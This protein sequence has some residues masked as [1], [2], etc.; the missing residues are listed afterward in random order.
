M[1]A[2]GSVK[3]WYTFVSGLNTEGGYFVTPDGTWK[4]GR[5]I[6]PQTDGSIERRN[7]LDFETGY[8]NTI[9]YF[10]TDTNTNLAITVGKWS[11][12]NS[13]DLLVVQVGTKLHFYYDTSSSISSTQLLKEINLSDYVV[14]DN[15]AYAV[16]ADY[17]C[18][19][20]QAYG[21][22]VVTHRAIN[23][24]LLT[25][26]AVGG[27]INAEEIKIKVR[28]FEGFNTF[29]TEPTDEFTEAE[30]ISYY[31]SLPGS[32]SGGEDRAIYN[33]KNQGWN[34]AQITAY[35]TA[36]ANKLPANTKI[37]FYGKDSSDNFSASLLNKQ[38][39]GTGLAPKGR[40]IL[41]A[42]N[43]TRTEDGLTVTNNSFFR[44]SV[45]GFFAGRIWYAGCPDPDFSSKV[46][47]SQVL[48][49]IEKVG[50]C[51]QRNDPTS[52]I[53]SDLLDSDGGNIEVPEAGQ[54]VKL[55]A[56][57]RGLLIF[58]ENG[59]FSVSGLD[60]IFSAANYQVEKIS[61]VGT[62][63]PET[64]VIVNNGIMFWS[65]DGVY[66][67]IP[68]AG[69]LS[70]NVD[71]VSNTA[72]RTFYN[73]ITFQAK[74]KACGAYNSTTNEIAWLYDSSTDDTLNINSKKTTMLVYN[75]SIDSWYVHD[76][77]NDS[78]T[79]PAFIFV[80]KPNSTVIEETTVVN[81]SGDIVSAD[82]LYSPARDI[83]VES[84][85][86]TAGK[87]SF[88]IISSMVETEGSNS[89][90]TAS[91]TTT[92]TGTNPLIGF[93]PVK[94]TQVKKSI[95]NWAL[96]SDDSDVDFGASVYLFRQY[97]TSF[98]T[99]DVSESSTY[100]A[101]WGT[102]SFFFNNSGDRMYV[103]QYN[104]TTDQA[105]LAYYTILA[106]IIT[107]YVVVLTS[108]T[109][110]VR[111]QILFTDMK[112]SFS[113]VTVDGETKNNTVMGLFTIPSTI[114]VGSM[115]LKS[116]TLDDDGNLITPVSVDYRLIS[117]SNDTYNMLTPLTNTDILLTR[118]PNLY[119]CDNGIWSRAVISIPVPGRLDTIQTT[120]YDTQLDNWARTYLGLGFQSFT[121][122]APAEITRYG[123]EYLY[124]DGY[125][126]KLG[127]DNY[128]Q[129][130]NFDLIIGPQNY[131]ANYK[132]IHINF[133]DF[134]NT[135]NTETKFID[136]HSKNYTVEN[137]AFV[138]TGYHMADNGPARQATGTY[139]TTFAK[140]TETALD[141]NGD[142]INPSKINMEVRWDF[143]DNESANK[144]STAV[145]VYRPPRMYIGNPGDTYD[146]GYPLVISKSKIRGR[147]KALQFKYSS[148][149]GYD[150]KL[151]GWTGTFVGNTNV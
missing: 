87:Y 151:V 34:D 90:F 94:G 24:I 38:E 135:R 28:D 108:T 124:T 138:L 120:D 76:L 62:V 85:N 127:I 47:F 88:K 12:T 129:K 67:I 104:R 101:G 48:D 142:P 14:G 147:G 1:A 136:W 31:L 126:I 63:F 106:G 43:P 77:T 139:L 134:N 13:V 20:A 23:P 35:K 51:Y 143:T 18:S 109:T 89:V 9:G 119:G 118:N 123:A 10:P 72:I 133:A 84:V 96:M 60:G 146:D 102:W 8:T 19:F 40:Y 117:S 128:Y 25:Y 144:W 121:V 53:L 111:N 107:G 110:T 57:G 114:N 37:W 7:G 50:D 99:F 73:D 83:T 61:A 81:S 98:V 122:Y 125:T 45:T 79:F 97:G 6:I 68:Q 22:L 42:F 41:E 93:T 92:I 54:I 105:R 148:E 5:N 115:Y 66:S 21:A 30:W 86:T 4:Q 33:L 44:P 56:L 131:N 58:A 112:R 3:D 69:G 49:T 32:Y 150:M 64:V 140:R 82:I 11:P 15:I 29:G 95:Y 145:N 27:F 26:E 46:Y 74:T 149:P 52:E 70:F 71:N 137:E 80:S 78:A 2:Q 59:I 17:P 55:I 16:D 100:H 116:I 39:F 91:S 103:S 130:V 36:N 75:I 113:S 141:E 65:T 132:A